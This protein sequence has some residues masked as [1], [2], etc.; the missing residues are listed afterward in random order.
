MHFF[1]PVPLMRLVEVIGA[2][3]T[4]ERTL[5]RALALAHRLGKK[6]VQVQDV[7][8]FLVNLIGRAYPTEALHIQNEGVAPVDMIDRIMREAAGFRMGPFEFMDL[9]GIDVNFPATRFIYEGF[10]HASRLKSTLLHKSL[11][12]SGRF[13]RKTGRGF[14]NYTSEKGAAPRGQEDDRA[15]CEESLPVFVAESAPAFQ[16]LAEQGLKLEGAQ[17]VDALLVSPDGEDAATAAVRLNLDPARVVAIDS[18]GASN[19]FLTLMAPVGGNGCVRRLATRLGRMG[20]SVAVIRNSPGFVAPPILAMIVNLTCEVAQIGVSVPADIDLA[21]GLAQN[22]PRGPFEWAE[23][24]GRR[25]V[26]D[27][28]RHIQEI[29][30]SDRYRPSLWLRRCAMLGLPMC[31]VE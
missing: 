28:L 19:Q 8:S 5:S 30:G 3:D 16:V 20:Y 9:T 11:F 6:A 15:A 26:F 27:I 23:L 4:S 21:M 31:T 10:Q 17:S 18:T 13:G 2:A 24:L 12:K 1:S 22:Y 25:R 29:T 7:P 14:H